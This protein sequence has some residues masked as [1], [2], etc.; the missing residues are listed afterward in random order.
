MFISW[1]SVW[2]IYL[3]FMEG[4]I[5]LTLFKCESHVLFVFRC[6]FCGGVYIMVGHACATEHMWRSENNCS[7]LHQVQSL[8]DMQWRTYW[9]WQESLGNSKDTPSPTK[10]HLLIPPK[11]FHQLDQESKYLSL[12]GLFSFKCASGKVAYICIHSTYEAEAGQ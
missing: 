2:F 9:E 11:H 10:P 1:H 4:P 8:R 3:F 7:V 6:H 5:L 12:R